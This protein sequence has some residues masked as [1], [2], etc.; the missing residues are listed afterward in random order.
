MSKNPSKVAMNA[1]DKII[2]LFEPYEGS[3]FDEIAAIIDEEMHS[4]EIMDTLWLCKKLVDEAL[5]KF[6]WGASALDAEA[7]QILNEA[8]KVLNT[9]LDR[10]VKGESK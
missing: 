3:Y 9:T 1:A 8:P 7:I 4:T 6:N 2:L 5:P 10:L